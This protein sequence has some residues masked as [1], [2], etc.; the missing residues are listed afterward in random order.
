[1][2]SRLVPIHVLA[3]VGYVIEQTVNGSA[4]LQ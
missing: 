2:R 4:A 3:M 1:M